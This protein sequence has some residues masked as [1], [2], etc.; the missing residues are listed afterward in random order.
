MVSKLTFREIWST[1][2][3]CVLAAG[4]T[5]SLCFTM[6]VHSTGNRWAFCDME[7]PPV[8]SHQKRLGQPTVTSIH[9]RGHW[10]QPVWRR[11]EIIFKCESV[12]YR[13]GKLTK[14]QRSSAVSIH[15]PAAHIWGTQQK[16]AIKLKKIS[17]VK[18]YSIYKRGSHCCSAAF[19]WFVYFTFVLHSF[20]FGFVQL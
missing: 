6:T 3:L 20:A 2:N 19:T 7:L 14:S 9:C 17:M 18:W 1:M 11:Q 16:D 13:K 8:S 4:N 10:F 12:D 5:F 15:A